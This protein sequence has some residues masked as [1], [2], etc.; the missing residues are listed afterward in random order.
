MAIV[1]AE[2]FF[3]GAATSAFQIEG[4]SHADWTGW[5]PLAPSPSLMTDHYRRFREDVAL[6]RALGLNAYRFSLEWSRIQP[7]ED[8]W[9]EE[10]LEHYRVLVA[11]VVAAGVEPVVTLHHFSNPA[12]L[13]AAAPW[14]S[15]AAAER[16]AAFVRRVADALPAVRIW[17]TFNEPMV[18]LLGGYLAGCTPPGLQSPAALLAALRSVLAA[19]AQAFAILRTRR[20]GA[21]VGIAH[22]MA[23]FAPDRRWH[24]V[25]RL[26]AGLCRRGFNQSLLEALTAG[27]TR[28]ALPFSRPVPI[29][30]PARDTLDFIGVN[31]Y[32]RL[33][34]RFRFGRDR[35]RCL[36]VFHR[37]R[38]RR[39]LTDMGWEEYPPGL[40]AVLREAAA[41]GLPL[42]VTENGVATANDDR[43]ADFIRRHVSELDACRRAG[44]D[45]RGYFYWSLTDTY[46]WLHGF[47]KRFGLYRVD[48]RTLE[49]TPTTAARAY[50][51]LVREHKELALREGGGRT[52]LTSI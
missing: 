22:N 1:A 46:E 23:V 40:S 28:L 17:V 51:S 45:V 15:L 50:A 10:A 38:G 33:H 13:H 9:D 43:K 31:Y 34:T 41:F 52:A 6:L 29:E 11:E 16:F 36:E 48:W 35:L 21:R 8:R 2:P 7:R 18:M 30:A 25:D 4:S 39:G 5:D 44:I 26:L 37:D 42:L 32:Q 3:W 27:H 14:T 47:S 49:R 12:W 19:H 20:P 24:P